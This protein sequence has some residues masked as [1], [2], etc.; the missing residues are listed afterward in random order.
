[1]RLAFRH[2]LQRVDGAR[3]TQEH[4]DGLIP[5]IIAEAGFSQVRSYDRL[6]TVWGSLE[7][8]SSQR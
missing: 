8:L 1:M 3:N 4:A 2:L 6:R 7:L 5:G